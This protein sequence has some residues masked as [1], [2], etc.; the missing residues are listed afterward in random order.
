[1]TYSES[2]II[3]KRFKIRKFQDEEFLLPRKWINFSSFKL[4]A[5]IL[6]QSLF[7]VAA[8]SAAD[9][10]R[11]NWEFVPHLMLLIK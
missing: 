5:W 7:R 8:V 9:R 1:M 2:I 6:E 11:D 4:P 10:D 3:I